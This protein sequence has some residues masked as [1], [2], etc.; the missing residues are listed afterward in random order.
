MNDP[1]IRQAVLLIHGIGEQRPMS[2]LRDFVTALVGDDFRS[3]PDDLSLSF[4]LRRLTYEQPVGPE[5]VQTCF[6]EY[7]WAYRLRDTKYEHLRGWAWHLL[8]RWPWHVPWRWLLILSYVVCWLTAFLLLCAVVAVGTAAFFPSSE[9]GALVAALRPRFS[10]LWPL[11]TLLFPLTVSGFLLY[12]VGDAARYLNPAPANVAERQ[13]IRSDGVALLRGL[14]KARNERGGPKY[15]RIIVVGHSLGSV[16]GYD[17]L[18]FYWAEVHQQGA[19]RLGAESD[20]AGLLADLARGPPRTATDY[21]QAQLAVWGALA[22]E[23]PWRITHFVTLGSPLTYADFL[24]AETAKE[25]GRRQD[26]KELPRCPPAAE[27]ESYCFRA[28]GPGGGE[29]MMLHHAALFALTRW[30]NFYF[31][32]DLIGGPVAHH[33]GD[34]V[35]DIPCTFGPGREGWWLLF[36]KRSNRLW[37]H[38]WYWRA[39]VAHTCRTLL[40]GVVGELVRERASIMEKALIDLVRR[41]V[42]AENQGGAAGGA[43]ADTILAP[44]FVGLNRA[45]GK[46]VGRQTLL[47]DIADAGPKP[48]NPLRELVDNEFWARVSGELGVVRSLV[49][50]RHR[51]TKQITGRYRNTHVFQWQDGRPVCVAWQVT[52]VTEPVLGPTS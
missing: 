50:T 44:D 27:K 10:A 3:K 48:P 9:L 5:R 25:L 24:L 14:H 4:E 36:K 1:P 18:K 28:E 15:D 26:Q 12:W 45:R 8:C 23:K 17:I 35:L 7:Y 13:A 19:L 42:G 16:I 47:K 29:E 41:L 21:Q 6:F 38:V 33:F 43:E 34:G 11:L 52:E 40:Q 31:P 37:S 49:V 32:G 2:N 20:T 51:D 22:Q 46:E 30:T 39:D